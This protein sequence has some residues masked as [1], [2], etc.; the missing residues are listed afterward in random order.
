M[1]N[2]VW[3]VHGPGRNFVWYVSTGN[4][5]VSFRYNILDSTVLPKRKEPAHSNLLF[6]VDADLVW[7]TFVLF[8]ALPNFQG[9]T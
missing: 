1:K 9:L 3:V 5:S 6:L 7:K 2:I 8:S 4:H